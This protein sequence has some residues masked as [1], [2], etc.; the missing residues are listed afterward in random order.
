[1]SWLS[2]LPVLAATAGMV[3][4]PGLVI[5]LCLRFRGFAALALAPAFSAA[6]V[7]FFGIVA[8]IVGIEWN[9]VTYAGGAAITAAAA[10]GLSTLVRRRQQRPAERTARG[11]AW[12]G[13]WIPVAAAAL[14]G[15]MILRRLMQLT[16][17]PENFAQNFDNVFHLNAIRYV[18]DTGTASSLTLGNLQGEGDV[19]SI[20]PA[21]WHAYGA[22]TMQLTGADVAVAE[23]AVNMVGAA[24]IWPLACVFL[25]RTLFGPKVVVTLAAGVL[26]AVQ[27]AFPYLVMVW[28][29][30]FPNAFSL[31]M[32]P[33]AI[34]VVVLLVRGGNDAEQAS[35]LLWWAALLLVLAGMSTAHMG[36]V[37]ALLVFIL[38]LLATAWFMRLRALI[39]RRTAPSRLVGFGVFTL[40]AAAALAACWI[41][42]RPGF[43]DHWGPSTTAGGALGEA[44]TN[45]PMGGEANWIVTVLALTGVIQLFRQRQQRWVAVAY[46]LSIWLYVVDASV[47]RGFW[48]NFLTGT[49]Y[50]DTYRLAALL[51]VMATALAALGAWVLADW[52]LKRAAAAYTRTGRELPAPSVRRVAAAVLAA[53]AVA[54]LAVSTYF[55]PVREYIAGAMPLYRFDE[56]SPMLTPTELELIEELGDY[57]PEDAVIAN[58]PWNGSS[59]AYAFGGWEVLTPHLF[60]SP[61][62]ERIIISQEL[63][64]GEFTP[65]VCAAV[66]DEDVE[67]V[68]DFGGRF[69]MEDPGSADFPGVTDLAP[70]PGLELVASTGE[71]ANLYRVTGC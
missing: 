47:D 5:A 9:P 2:T 41:L 54:G 50:Q 16:G 36:T 48:R 58:N 1:M 29:P 45:G 24:V 59:M 13:L 35:P 61:D 30:L 56:S 51:P 43:Y 11:S 20:Y 19:V 44:L 67:Y 55:G 6:V 42:L 66:Q 27:V 65:E 23:N 71:E 40:L 46:G 21:V 38:P 12:R 28:G 4:V 26:S 63:G 32:L 17:G 69:L 3:L 70:V 62:P 14:G 64:T 39:R 22:M 49:W 68:L 8:E 10:F 33:L 7:G 52:V 34:A 53:V 57:V 31:S 37:N 15:A 18:L 60:A 25:A